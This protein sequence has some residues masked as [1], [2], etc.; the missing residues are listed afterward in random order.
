MPAG[1]LNCLKN[2]GKIITK[3]LK[4]DKYIK[5]CK[6]GGKWYP[7]ETHVKKGK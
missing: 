5:M 4:D 3:T 6:L 1:F 7:G 2:G